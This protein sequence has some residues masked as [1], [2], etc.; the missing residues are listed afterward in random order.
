MHRVALN[1]VPL[2]TDRFSTLGEPVRRVLFG[3]FLIQFALVWARLLLPLPLLANA[4]WPDGLLLVLAAATTVAALARRLPGQNVMLASGII[5]VI[6]GGVQCLNSSSGIPFGPCDFADNIGQEL[7]HPLRWA[8][9][10]LWIVVVLTSRG[11]ARLML[12]PWRKTRSYGYWV[13]GVTAALVVLFDLGLEPF[14][15][16]VKDFWIWHPTKLP[17][18]WY[19]TPWVNFVGRGVMAVLIL[20]F[21]TP[22]LIN[23]KHSKSV[24]D[25]HPLILWLLLNG[26]FATGLA[27][28]QLWPAVAVIGGGSLVVTV[29]A[30]RG[31]RW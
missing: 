16:R 7:F 18:D 27:A 13:I 8:V 23:K 1:K 26:L 17:F 19:S 25:Y 24:S 30:V 4:R 10:L 3:L 31:A 22:S 5:A 21:A 2:G 11:V 15:T 9:P 29:F 14:A 20:A 28:K 6:S 12:R